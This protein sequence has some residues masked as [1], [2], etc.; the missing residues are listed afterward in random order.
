MRLLITG[1]LGNVGRAA[2]AHL[3][4]AGHEVVTFDRV[5]SHD[6]AWEHVTG[7]LRDAL[8]VR[9]AMRGVDAVV[10][11][12]TYPGDGEPG[13]EDAVLSI[14]VG[15]TWN[16]MTAAVEAGVSRVVYVS[17]VNALGA[18][19]NEHKPD[20]LPLTDRH[21]RNPVS[22]YQLG[23]HLSEEVCRSYTRRCGI[24]TIC[25]R[26]TLVAVAPHTYRLWRGDDPHL[27]ERLAANFGAYIDRRDLL[28]AID[29]ALAVEGIDHDG[30]LLAARDIS[31]D[32]LTTAEII[33]QYAPAVPWPGSSLAEWTRD[34]PYRSPF[35]C[36]HAAQRL[37]WTPKHSWRDTPSADDAARLTPHGDHR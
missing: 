17:S 13:E 31:T 6:L 7:D 10:H 26:P 12:G 18:I 1:G 33:E 28:S 35:D 24:P 3:T 4:A 23:K 21:P 27:H 32:R 20:F 14:A 25:L 34:D 9:Q 8:G 15:G 5:T 16:V 29:L 2:A 19:K 22:I 37:G 30:F 36:S 11:A